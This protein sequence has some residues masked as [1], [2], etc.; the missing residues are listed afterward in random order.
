MP[1]SFDEV[2]ECVEAALRRVGR[3]VVLAV[4][5]ALGKPVPLID[6]FWRRALRD[7][8]LDLTIVTA[9]TL[10]R[11]LP[12][13][14]LERRF[15]APLVERVFGDY[16]EPEYLAA[17]RSGALPSNVRVI[18][19]YLEPGAALD[20]AAAQTHYLSS[21]YTHVARDLAARGVNV[22]AQLVA[23]RNVDGQP[24]LSLGSNPDVTLD[25]LP[26]LEAARRA[27]REIVTIAAVHAQMPFMYGSAEVA[28][29]TFDFVLE[30]PR[31]DA[32]LFGPPNAPLS[33]VDHA[34]GLHASALLRDGG[35]LQIGIGELGDALCYAL[36]LRHQQNQA[37]VQALRDVGTER[38]AAALVDAEGGREPFRTG[39]FGSTEMFVDQMLDLY[40][41]G[42]L[43]RCVYDSLPLSRLIATGHAGDR[44]DERILGDLP[45]VGIGPRLDAAQFEHLRHFGVFR[46]DCAWRDGRIVS[47]EGESIPADLADP[48]A[49]AGL[50]AHCLGRELRNGHVVHAGFFLGPRNF[51]AALREMPEGELRRFD[52]RGVG[53]INQLYGPDAELRVL[54]RRDA[55]FVNTT[56][57]VTMLGAA[58]SDTLED[59][60]VVSG[61]GG[62]YNFVAMAHALPGARSVVCVRA[63]RTKGGQVRSN[64]VWSYGNSTVPRHLRDLVVTEYGIA[65]LRGRTDGECV[66]ALLNV[67]DSRFQAEL[68]AQAK[69]AR[70]LPA[71]YAVPEAFRHNTPRQLERAL[72]S[73]RQAG[74]FSDYPFGTELTEEEIILTRALRHLRDATGSR[75]Q[76]LCT[77]AAATFERDADE[78]RPALRRMGLERPVDRRGRLLRRLLVWALH[79]TR[80]GAGGPP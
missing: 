12:S 30:N 57:M 66:A 8:G 33:S 11:P 13:G 75:W 41:A 51:Y 22:I 45:H 53:W 28:A 15:A 26:R 47:P 18:E 43:R 16:R 44:F 65:D 6:E 27:G 5:L 25:L 9:L 60:R 37:W 10:R 73:H 59:G 77:I 71:D 58:I 48:K 24:R 78:D 29:D 39:L 69:A 35:T 49:V 52:M 64:L 3:K 50:A 31:Y 46:Q 32:T 40:R 7:P 2:G 80:A 14:D 21:N 70:K 20:V 19:F 68:L 76:R 23:R 54:Q 63:T 36:L 67:A 38:S 56:M 72:A 61:V 79:R 17:Q 1:Q 74:L 4:P 62:Q 34:I 55:R 42:I